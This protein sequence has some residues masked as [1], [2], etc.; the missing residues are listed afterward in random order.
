MHPSA[1]KVVAAA[2]AA[3]LDI[4]V[5]EYPEG[6]RTAEQAAAAVGCEV[7]RIVK[8]L[9]FAVD[10]TPVL[11]LVAGDNRLDEDRLVAAAGGERAGR[12]DADVVRSTTGFAIGGV[13]PFGHDT[14]LATFV[15][16]SLLAHD[17]VW[18]AAGTPRHV[19]EVAPGD[20]VRLSGGRAVPLAAV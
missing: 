9:V 6:T 14:Q 16:E 8:S 7:A 19:F 1:A 13:P 11:A 5:V 2:S 20:L 12:A 17:T 15:D 4:D 3:G 10:G 18:A